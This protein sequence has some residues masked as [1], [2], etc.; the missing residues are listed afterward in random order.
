MDQGALKESCGVMCFVLMKGSFDPINPRIRCG[1]NVGPTPLQGLDP[2]LRTLGW[3][4]PIPAP[5]LLPP[6]PLH[7][8]LFLLL[9]IIKRAAWVSCYQPSSSWQVNLYLPWPVSSGP[10]RLGD[11]SSGPWNAWWVD[12]RIILSQGS[13]GCWRPSFPSCHL[14]WFPAGSPSAS[15]ELRAPSPDQAAACFPVCWAVSSWEPLLCGC[16]LS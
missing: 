9:I 12:C 15:L 5:L 1:R 14:S 13:S 11:F 16:V 8:L 3:W 4:P 10:H 7:L 6:P 2:S